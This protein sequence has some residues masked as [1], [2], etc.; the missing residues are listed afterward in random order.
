[1]A[2]RLLTSYNDIL[3]GPED[4]G[5]LFLFQSMVTYISFHKRT[6]RF[7]LWTYINTYRWCGNY[8]LPTVYKQVLSCGVGIISF[9]LCTVVCVPCYKN[10]TRPPP[11]TSI[12][13]PQA[14]A[15]SWGWQVQLLSA[16]KAPS[17]RTAWAKPSWVRV[18]RACPR[19]NV[20]LSIHR[21]TGKLRSTATVYFISLQA[22]YIFRPR[23]AII[24]FCTK[25]WK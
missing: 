5:G 7:C 23:R 9:T 20:V 10:T 2:P 14:A 25:L 11:P 15:L 4:G 12:P 24:M 3:C 18:I 8:R 17:F 16:Y 1:M 19:T 13:R 21:Q 22:G 6:V